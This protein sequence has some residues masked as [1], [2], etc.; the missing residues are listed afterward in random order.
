[1]R[2][3]DPR[4]T[5]WAEACEML[6]QVERLQRQFFR[7]SGAA[8]RPAWEPPVDVFETEDA[9]LIV[10]ALPGVA[11]EDLRVVAE[12]RVLTVIGERRLPPESAGAI[13]R[14]EI[15]HGRFE[16]RLALPPGRYE[17][18][19]SNLSDG[20]LALQLRKLG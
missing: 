14:L 5:M 3:N 9:L 13:H 11:A 12:N 18:T 20:C 4:T 1:M 7:P 6:D 16:R 15:P 8:L 10:V 19:E 2:H 17:L